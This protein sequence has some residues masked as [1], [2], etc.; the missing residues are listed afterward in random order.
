[1]LYLYKREERVASNYSQNLALTKSYTYKRLIIV[2][3]SVMIDHGAFPACDDTKL[4]GRYIP[5][6]LSR[7][8]I[9]GLLKEKLDEEWVHNHRPQRYRFHRTC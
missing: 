1:M 5:S 7:N 3:Y 9:T 2:V 6:T 8:V 4:E